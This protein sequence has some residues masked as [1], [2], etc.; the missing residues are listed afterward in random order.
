MPPRIP[1]LDPA[2]PR[3]R[4]SDLR[5]GPCAMAQV[6]PATAA[7]VVAGAFAGLAAT[8]L[9]S[10]LLL[11]TPVHGQ[12][13]PAQAQAPIQGQAPTEAPEDPR[14]L[15]WVGCWEPVD[16]DLGDGSELLICVTPAEDGVRIE[17]FLNGVSVSEDPIVADGSLHPMAEGGCEGSRQ[18][19]WSA[20]GRRVFLASDLICGA[21]AQ[22]AT[23]GLFAMGADG[24]DWI[25]IQA[26][27][28]AAG[29]SPALS[30]RRF[31][32]ASRATLARH[33]QVAPGSGLGL[34][35]QTSRASAARAMDGAALAEASEAAGKEVTSALVV[36]MGHAYALDARTLRAYRDAGVDPQVLDMMIAMS[37][38]DRFQITAYGSAQEVLPE[39]RPDRGSP[40]YPGG[41]V[42]QADLWCNPWAFGGCFALGTRFTYRRH[43]AW[44]YGSFGWGFGYGQGWDPFFGGWGWSTGPRYVIVAPG[45]RTFSERGLLS[46]EGYRPPASRT[47]QAR[48]AARSGTTSGSAAPTRAA[49]APA[50]RP[51][52]ST[53]PTAGGAPPPPAATSGGATSGA[54]P[55][56]R[57][58]SGGGEP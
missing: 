25:E 49:P 55:A 48:P 23:R 9:L 6:L 20:D 35:I 3:V 50:P 51:A 12:A 45:G 7:P 54:R 19:S 16:E 21:E 28:T 58:G 34:A 37:W 31:Q 38:P 13:A 57:R 10:L 42:T 33:D 41:F 40:P 17:T 15:P 36:E 53:S 30:V 27:T 43:L 5:S 14:W 24:L 18:A 22:R 56:Q 1:P 26:M 8:L 11:P 2:R 44:S 52:T 39:P 32:P 47:N 4:S 29:A 46:D